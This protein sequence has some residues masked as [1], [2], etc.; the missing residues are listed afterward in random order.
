MIFCLFQLVFLNNFKIC[1]WTRLWRKQGNNFHFQP[2]T[3]HIIRQNHQTCDILWKLY[4]MRWFPKT[5][6]F[7]RSGVVCIY[8][9]LK[10]SPD[11]FHCWKPPKNLTYMFIKWCLSKIDLPNMFLSRSL[12]IRCFLPIGKWEITE[13]Y[14]PGL[15]NKFEGFAGQFSSLSETELYAC[16]HILCSCNNVALRE[17]SGGKVQDFGTNMWY[18]G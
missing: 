2:N 12:V 9:N 10:G 11:F 18:R 14:Q 16:Y 17:K 5:V 7:L 13:M 15:E 4:D 1:F 8:V 3:D 6:L